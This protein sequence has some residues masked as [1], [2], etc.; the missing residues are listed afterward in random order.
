MLRDLEGGQWNNGVNRSE[1]S[2]VPSVW[3][4]VSTVC[5]GYGMQTWAVD[6]SFLPLAANSVCSAGIWGWA[7]GAGSAVC[8]N[9]QR[10]H[11]ARWDGVR[12]KT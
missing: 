1:G 7:E 4:P 12:C 10:S 3:D 5:C 6:F 9:M 2:D 11:K 8:G